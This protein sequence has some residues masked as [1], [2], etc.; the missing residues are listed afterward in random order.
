RRA[1]HPRHGGWPPAR[2]PPRRPRRGRRRA[3]GDALTPHRHCEERSDEA[4]SLHQQTGGYRL[5]RAPRGCLD[6]LAMTTR[7]S[8]MRLAVLTSLFLLL[9]GCTDV[10]VESPEPAPADSTADLSA[11]F[12][13]G[14]EGAFVLY[15]AQSGVTTR[16][17]PARAAEPR[18]PAS[19]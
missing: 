7:Y 11:F 6:T 14:T 4:I 12:P 13:E 15:D 18:T 17:N 16:Y 9:V 19:T 3:A 8:A 10:S 5:R 1:A 2:E